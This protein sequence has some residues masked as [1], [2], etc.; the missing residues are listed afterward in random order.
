MRD[1]EHRQS[2]FAAQL[3]E[4]V[5]NL[6]LDGDIERGGGLVGDEQ[7]RTVHDGHGDHHALP[8]ASRKLVR[9]TAGALVRFVDGE[10]AHAFDS[11]MPCFGFRDAVMGQHGFGDLLAHAHHWIERG[12]RL[13]KNHGDA[14]AAKLAQFIGGQMVR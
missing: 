4:Q 7:L 6:L 12:H 2:I 5:E 9:I 13:L 3:V 8:H 11:S 1:E 10:V 14:R